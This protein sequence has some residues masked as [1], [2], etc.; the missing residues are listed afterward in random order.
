MKL[1]SIRH[2]IQLV[3]LILTIIGIFNSLN[4]LIFIGLI[5]LVGP[6]FCGWICPF[7]FIQDLMSSIRRR[8]NIKNITIQYHHYLK[9]M[10]YILYILLLANVSFIIFNVLTYDPRIAFQQLLTM[11]TLSIVTLV[12]FILFLTL[13]LFVDRF[14]CKYLCVEGAK[15][16]ILSVARVFKIHRTDA[17]IECK[18]CDH[19]CPMGIQVT[20]STSVN[21]LECISC[22]SCIESCSVDR[23]IRLKSKVVPK[24]ILLALILL[25]I[26]V[27]SPQLASTLPNTSAFESTVSNTTSHFDED[28]NL[29]ASEGIEILEGTAQGFKGNITV[30]VQKKG[31]RIENIVV[32]SHSDDMPW[33]YKSIGVIDTMLNAQST[34]VDSVSGATYTSRG[35]INATKD[36][37]G[38]TFT[39]LAPSS[40]KRRHH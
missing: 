19:A 38:E 33:Y 12:I 39:D 15:H 2:T 7:G 40:G 16:S 26:L 18:K 5:L 3:F 24:N 13:S 11:N 9:Y 31:T 35:I 17:C 30:Q 32:T 6:A 8:L 22:L 27:I 37:L 1:S 14:F 34:D 28:G 21:A 36:A 10:R 4:W 29:L 20:K 25:G 23:A